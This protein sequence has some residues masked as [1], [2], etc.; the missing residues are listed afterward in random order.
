[1]KIF[2]IKIALRAYK[3]GLAISTQAN[4]I[5]KFVSPLQTALASYNK[6]ISS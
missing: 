3:L 2:K 4:K 6:K 1:L 5:L